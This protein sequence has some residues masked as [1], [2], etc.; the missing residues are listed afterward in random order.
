MFVYK[1]KKKRRII[2]NDNKKMWNNIRDM[3]VNPAIFLS[4]YLRFDSMFEKSSIDMEVLDVE[5][6]S[7]LSKILL[8]YSIWL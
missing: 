5:N 6:L 3:I 7:V 1:K 8:I 2:V 4:F